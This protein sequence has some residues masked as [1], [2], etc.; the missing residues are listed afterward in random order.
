MNALN[1]SDVFG[2]AFQANKELAKTAAYFEAGRIINNK[3]V[4]LIVPKLPMMVRGY[5]QT[6]FGK[7]ALANLFLV[8]VQK[9]KPENAMLAKLGYAAVTQAYTEAF[10]GLNLEGL[11]DSFLGDSAIAKAAGL[12]DQAVAQTAAQ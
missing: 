5:A 6:A 2:V 10:E 4:G 3:L 7:L 8:A 11:I 12:V 9:F 1:L